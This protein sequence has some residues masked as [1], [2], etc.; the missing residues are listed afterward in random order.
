L[1]C[2]FKT[3][4]ADGLIALYQ[5]GY[6]IA[7]FGVGPTQE[8]GLSLRTIFG[9]TDVLALLMAGLAFVVTKPADAIEQS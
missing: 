5:F 4:V 3:S 8:L 1:I 7:A 6:G 2:D 9:W